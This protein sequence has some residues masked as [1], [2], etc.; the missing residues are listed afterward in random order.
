MDGHSS[1]EAMFE[2]LSLAVDGE[3][4]EARCRQVLDH[5]GQCEPCRRYLDSLRATRDALGAAG[6]TPEIDPAAA[7]AL[8]QECR[9]ALL[10]RCPDLLGGKTAP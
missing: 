8:L 3:T 10:A 5:A 2:G 4:M 9:E 7:Q 1:C 6:R